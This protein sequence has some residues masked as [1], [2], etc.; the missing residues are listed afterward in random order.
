MKR[1]TAESYVLLR[2]P[3]DTSELNVPAV[4]IRKSPYFNKRRR[5]LIDLYNVLLTRIGEDRFELEKETGVVNVF[6]KI[7]QEVLD[8][9]PPSYYELPEAKEYLSINP[10]YK[11]GYDVTY[12]YP[13]TFW[14]FYSLVKRV[15]YQTWNYSKNKQKNK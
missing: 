4:D 8:E 9:F 3:S 14:N 1:S 6:V 2:D 13:W 7:R 15:L 12:T 10:K 11:D 5:D